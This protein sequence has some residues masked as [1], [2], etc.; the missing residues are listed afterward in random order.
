M[1]NFMLG[2]FYNFFKR[3][4]YLFQLPHFTDEERL[5]GVT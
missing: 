2:T 3:P 5:K 4:Y 1:E